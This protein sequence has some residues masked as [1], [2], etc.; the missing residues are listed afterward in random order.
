MS[1]SKLL[2]QQATGITHY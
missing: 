1:E 2:L